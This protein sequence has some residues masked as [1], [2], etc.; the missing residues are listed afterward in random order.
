MI[1]AGDAIDSTLGA[2]LGLSVMAAAGLGNLCSDVIGQ[3]SGGAIE[4]TAGRLGLPDPCM[5]ESQA[6]SGIARKVHLGSSVL[7][8]AVGCLLGMIPLLFMRDDWERKIDHLFNDLDKNGDGVL[9]ISEIK[10]AFARLG[11]DAS[12]PAYERLM[13]RTKSAT[14]DSKISRTEFASI[15]TELR[16]T[17]Q[18]AD[19][20]SDGAINARELIALSERLGA[21]PISEDAAVAVLGS[22]GRVLSEEELVAVIPRA[23]EATA[24]AQ[25]K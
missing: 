24:S 13:K 5:S 1:T 3:A 10:V 14:G 19:S 8:I 6:K 7:G 4:A 11:I 9:S 16:S 12:H 25:G 2:S 22:T 15:A 23:I 17:L 20:N 21:G 18:S